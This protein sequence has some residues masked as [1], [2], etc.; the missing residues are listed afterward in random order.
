LIPS[1]SVAS[2]AS[3]GHAAILAE[4][5]SVVRTK[6]NK[7]PTCLIQ[8]V[9]L[10]GLARDIV[11]EKTSHSCCHFSIAKLPQVVKAE[12]NFSVTVKCVVPTPGFKTCHV[13]TKLSSGHFHTTSCK[14][15]VLMFVPGKIIIPLAWNALIASTMVEYVPKSFKETSRRIRV[16][17]LKKQLKR[18]LFII[19]RQSEWIG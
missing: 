17:R 14:R 19:I 7:G 18:L 13:V 6:R 9:V 10:L 3:P 16:S 2:A 4:G 11:I 15:I 5:S 1:L 8:S 12:P